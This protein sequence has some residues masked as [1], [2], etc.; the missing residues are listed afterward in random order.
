[1]WAL[2]EDSQHLLPAHLRSSSSKQA[3]RDVTSNSA[4]TAA[5]ADDAHDSSSSSSERILVASW[6]KQTAVLAHPA[7]KVFITHGG[8]GSVHEC[9]ALGK[10]VP[11][12]VPFS[13]GADH[14]TIGQQLES[15]GL[16]ML[17]KPA[18]LLLP[19]RLTKAV[20][21]LLGDEELRRR[22]AGVAKAWEQAGYGPKMAAELLIEF[23]LGREASK[24]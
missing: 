20:E 3:P 15:R 12:V 21:G 1:M 13:N 18:E 24:C 16:G 11:L 4:D 10:A 8:L 14:C 23:A 17:L 7:T 5:A 2:R 6:V 9:L 22:V 19:G